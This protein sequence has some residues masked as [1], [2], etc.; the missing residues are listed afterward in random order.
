VKEWVWS[1][2]GMLLTGENWS[3]GRETLYIVGGRWMNVNGAL[4]EWYWQ[5]R[6]DVLEEKNYIASVVVEWMGKE[7]WW[8][9][10]GRGKLSTGR[11]TYRMCVRWMNGYGALVEWDWRKNWITGR[12][13]LYSVA[14]RWMNG[15]GA[16]VEWYCQGRTEV[17]GEKLSQWHL[18]K[19][20]SHTEW[21]GNEHNKS[22]S[23]SH[24]RHHAAGA[25]TNQLML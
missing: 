11:E 19:H 5:G 18:V 16:S 13:T 2:G 6:T 1:I 10:T 12:E 20:K 4:V 17:P 9:G 23:T 21:P 24:S 7:H 22:V 3:I 15:Y 8:N 25:Y 14:G